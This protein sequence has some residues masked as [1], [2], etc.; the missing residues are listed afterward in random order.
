MSYI[1]IIIYVTI[2]EVVYSVFDEKVKTS[3]VFSVFRISS[4][5]SLFIVS[6]KLEGF[7]FYLG[8]IVVPVVSIIIIRLFF[9]E[10]KTTI[11][12]DILFF[13]FMV[14]FVLVMRY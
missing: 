7:L 2:L 10:N 6:I 11:K 5:V 12:N 14:I 8:I 1:I 3:W 9:S 13:F 4:V